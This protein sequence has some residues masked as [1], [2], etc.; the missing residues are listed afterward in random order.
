MPL[1]CERHTAFIFDR[2]AQTRLGAFSPLSSVTWER[3][4]DHTSEATVVVSPRGDECDVTL[5]LAAAGRSELVIYRGDER[6]WEGPI[7]RIAYEGDKVTITARDVSHYTSRCIMKQEYDNSYPNIGTAITRM[8]RILGT[9]LV[10]LEAQNPPI[11]VLPHI[12]AHH[13]EGDAGTSSRTLPFEYTVQEHMDNLAARG[14]L[15]Y[16]V[17]GR[18][19][20]LWDVH[21]PLGQTAILTEKDFIG[22]V[23]ITEYGMQ[24]ATYTAVTDGEGRAG[25]AGGP[26]PYYGLVEQLDM[27]YDE[28]SGDDWDEEGGA[29][30]PSIAELA[31][32]A[33]RLVTNPAPVVVRVPDNS[34]LNPNGTLAVA[35]LVPGVWIPLQANLPGRTLSQMQK[36]HTVKIKEDGQNGETIQV[37][38]VPAAQDDAVEGGGEA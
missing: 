37:T 27:A 5:G 26:D 22:D 30:P 8:E 20:H 17:I 31:S 2:G 11:N 28:E 9:E 18:A 13:N 38:L 14:G 36:L 35:D 23:I 10:R 32:Q 25:E 15:D 21:K 34:T 7:I 1:W 3:T 33:Q 4:R 6:V 19:L 24:L 29:E 16:V 12:V